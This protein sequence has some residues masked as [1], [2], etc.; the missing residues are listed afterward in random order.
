[1]NTNPKASGLKS[2]CKSSL[3]LNKDKVILFFN[4]FTNYFI[5][6]CLNDNEIHATS[7]CRNGDIFAFADIA[8]LVNHAAGKVK[9]P[10]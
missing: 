3:F 5:T 1:M 8:L 2:W 6:S 4:D 10:Q 7:P 9:N